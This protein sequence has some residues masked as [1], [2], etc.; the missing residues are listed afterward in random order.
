M[1]AWGLSCPICNHRL[2]QF[3][4]EDTLQSFFFP[5]KPDF[6]KGG[7]TLECPNCGYNGTY[8]RTDLVYLP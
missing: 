6:P 8:Q 3:A 7:K 1:A 5:R 4:I 2:A